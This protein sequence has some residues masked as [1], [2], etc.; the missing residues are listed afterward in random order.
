M[1]SWRRHKQ[2]GKKENEDR[3]GAKGCEERVGIVRVKSKGTIR[4][5]EWK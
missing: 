5:D 1:L 4:E 3:G 2:G